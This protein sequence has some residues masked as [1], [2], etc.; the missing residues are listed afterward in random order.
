MRIRDPIHGTIP[1]GDPEVPLLD[2]RFFQRLRNVRQ[3]GFGELAFPGATHTRFAHSLGAMHVATRLFDTVFARASVPGPE[4]VRMRQAVRVAVLCH[5]IG[6]MPLSHA[7]ERI[8]P[9]RAALGLPGW[10]CEPSEGQADHEDFTARI[11]L[12]SSFT[13]VL[14]GQ[15]G[16]F[17]LSPAAI[18]SLVSGVEPPGGSAFVAGGRDFM[19]VLRQLVSGE[20]DSDRMDYLQRDSAF[21]GVNYGRFDLDWLVQNLMPIESEGRVYLAL[22]KAAIFAFEDFLLSRFHMFVSVYFHHTSVNFDEML[23]RY[24]LEEPGGFEIPADPERFVDCDDVTLATALRRSSNRWARRIVGRHGYKLVAQATELDRDYD[25]DA[26]SQALGAEGI[27]HFRS[28]S[29][30]VLSKYLADGGGPP[31]YVVDPHAGTTT[32]IADYT[33]L[34]QRYA[35][36]LHLK[37]VYCAP[38]KAERAR[39]LVLGA[40]RGVRQGRSAEQ[41]ASDER[42]R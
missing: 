21:T 37:R 40:V 14:E 5:D 36:A 10:L 6:H 4:R 42:R 23:R 2:S 24:Y 13:P 30:G 32:P 34:Y 28:E 20:L 31:L 1:V 15:L 38:E 12:D 41:T 35:G 19:P 17:G 16:P 27:E 3:L 9:T 39:Q 8:A 25:F 33:P 18:V 29:L 26:I 22:A 7:S 11:L